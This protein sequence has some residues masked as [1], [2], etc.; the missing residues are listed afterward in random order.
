MPSACSARARDGGARAS[1]SCAAPPPAGPSRRASRTCTRWRST[2]RASRGR[3]SRCS[4]APNGAARP[5]A[6]CSPRSWR[7]SRSGGTRARPRATPSGSPRSRPAT[8][9][10]APSQIA[11]RARAPAESSR[12]SRAK[13]EASSAGFARATCPAGRQGGARRQARDYR[14]RGAKP[15]AEIISF[16]VAGGDGLAAMEPE[17][18]AEIGEG[19]RGPDDEPAE[20]DAEAGLVAAGRVRR[21][22]QRVA[23]G[24]PQHD[25]EERGGARSDD[26]EQE[27]ARPRERTEEG[28][29]RQAQEDGH[30]LPPRQGRPR[31]RRARAGPCRGRATG[32]RGGSPPSPPATARRPRPRGGAPPAGSARAP[33]RRSSTRGTAR[34]ARPAR[35]GRTR[36]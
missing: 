18:H 28:P 12:A 32:S 15:P 16:A 35:R 11:S 13:F 24:G 4:R 22:G 33:D 26:A 5:A 1:S 7:T 36:R 19:E 2:T 21:D 31:A 29:A 17:H 23:A 27:D 25:R 20:R 34:R 3:R 30:D 14:R 6:T 10:R 8:P 9:A